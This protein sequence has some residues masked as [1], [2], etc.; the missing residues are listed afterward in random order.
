MVTNGARHR[1][2]L[3]RRSWSM[4]LRTFRQETNSKPASPVGSRMQA[5]TRLIRSNLSEVAQMQRQE[6]G[7]AQ[8][9]LSLGKA[10]VAK[11]VV[12]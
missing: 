12:R 4:F 9:I 10:D 1:S 5:N 11:L 6:L 8:S 2:M 7:L 3:R